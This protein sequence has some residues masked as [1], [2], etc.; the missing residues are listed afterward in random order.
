[1]QVPR[2]AMSNPSQIGM[3]EGYVC[4]DMST[5]RF[6]HLHFFVFD[7]LR[8]LPENVSKRSPHAFVPFSAG[9]RNCIGQTFAMNEMK[10][11]TALT[12]K[13][14][15]LMED[16]ESKPKMI[17]RLVLRSLNGIHIKIKPVEPEM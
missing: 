15:Q 14:Y 6:V 2:A 9:P 17:P 3:Y 10:V 7:P 12:L 13:R 4:G 16:P 8:F 11:V 1:M 5:H